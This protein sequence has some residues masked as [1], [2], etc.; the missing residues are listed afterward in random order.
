MLQ[1]KC[2]A[3]AD[4]AE[5]HGASLVSLSVCAFTTHAPAKGGCSFAPLF[6]LST[7]D[8]FLYLRTRRT[9]MRGLF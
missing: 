8:E 6:V 2:S 1:R 9:R 4:R 3:I 7:T 5:M